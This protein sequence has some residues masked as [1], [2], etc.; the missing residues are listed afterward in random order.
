MKLVLSALF[1]YR[2]HLLIIR[3]APTFLLIRPIPLLSLDTNIN[4][5]QLIILQCWIHTASLLNPSSY[6]RSLIQNTATLISSCALSFF[7]I[8]DIL[9]TQHNELNLASPRIALS[10]SPHSHSH[11]SSTSTYCECNDRDRCQCEQL[12]HSITK[13]H[14]AARAS[15]TT[16]QNRVRMRCNCAQ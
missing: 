6:G 2:I 8:Y 13:M 12:C 1:E 4:L 7:S 5:Q 10:P 9:G 14:S 16:T 11:L 3:T 15:E